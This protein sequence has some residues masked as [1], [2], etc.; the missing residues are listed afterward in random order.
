MICDGFLSVKRFGTG[1]YPFLMNCG[2]VCV[3]R[4]TKKVDLFSYSLVLLPVHLGDHWC[5]E[6]IN[7]DEK[8]IVNYDILGGNNEVKIMHIQ[9]LLF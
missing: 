2:Y 7:M 3:K 4:W 8:L 9:R 5:L 6:T 1:F